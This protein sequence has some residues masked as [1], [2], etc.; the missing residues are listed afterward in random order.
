[1]TSS[2]VAESA[3]TTCSIQIH[4]NT[5]AT[6]QTAATACADALANSNSSIANNND[7]VFF[8]TYVD[9]DSDATTFDSSNSTIS[10]RSAQ[11]AARK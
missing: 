7:N 11:I 5:V 3:N 9:V 1:V 10:H 2:R 8:M 4:G 6:C